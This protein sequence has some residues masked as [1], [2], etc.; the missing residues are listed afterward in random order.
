M[1]ILNIALQVAQVGCFSPNC[2]CRFITL[3]STMLSC[4]GGGASEQLGGRGEH[5]KLTPLGGS[6]WGMLPQENFRICM[7][8]LE[9]SQSLTQ[10]SRY[11]DFKA[12][13]GSAREAS[14]QRVISMPHTSWLFQQTALSNHG[15]F[16]PDLPGTS[17]MALFSIYGKNMLFLTL[18]QRAVTYL[19]LLLA[20]IDGLSAPW[21]VSVYTW[22]RNICLACSSGSA[23][24][25]R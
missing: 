3:W 7:L 11:L 14:F 24:R 17:W 5:A 13:T 9:P 4:R 2:Y 21:T 6:T 19:A 20:C 8:W 23:K 25:L 10:R 15:R 22:T 16:K 12:R 18:F 1:W